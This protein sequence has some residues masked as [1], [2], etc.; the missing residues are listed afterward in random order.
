VIASGSERQRQL[1]DIKIVN[2]SRLYPG[3]ERP[4]VDNVSLDIA[5]G[6]F[7]TFLGPSGS[8]KTTMLSMIAGFVQL[9]SGSILIDGKDVTTVKPHKRDLGVVFQH[10][11]LFPHFTVAANIAY[12]LEQRRF[13]KTE[14]TARVKAALEMVHLEEFADRLPRQLSGGQQQRVALARAIVYE[15]QAL[16][17]DEP[18]GALDK[19]LRDSMQLE[20][21][22]MH[23]EL[24]MTFVFV[25]HDQEEALTLSDRI[26]VFNNGRIE[27]V[28]T[29]EELYDKPQTLFVAKF[30]GESNIFGGDRPGELIVVRPERLVLFDQ[31]APLPAEL[32]KRDAV[33]SQVTFI[34]N[35]Y[36][37]QLQFDD[38]TVGS[39]MQL[40]ATPMSVRPGQRIVAAW[41]RDS[42]RS[43]ASEI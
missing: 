24:G 41:H 29:P 30:I 10:Y 22:R 25:T 34:G 6:E 9:S 3:A 13:S 15:P 28:G 33:V 43:I 38:G 5:G 8:G 36:K 2:A 32:L 16:L 23:R 7:M 40:T 39:S 42:Q 12:P 26:A 37:V 19:R 31:H 27:Q 17:L 20:I 4:A 1:H 11:A 18:L 35:H 14:I 21:A